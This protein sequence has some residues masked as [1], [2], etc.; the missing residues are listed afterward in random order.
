L[1]QKQLKSVRFTASSRNWSH[2]SITEILLATNFQIMPING[3]QHHRHRFRYYLLPN[4]FEKYLQDYFKHRQSTIVIIKYTNSFVYLPPI[5][6]PEYV[7][8]PGSLERLTIR[9]RY[10]AVIPHHLSNTTRNSGRS[11]VINVVVVQ[12]LEALKFKLRILFSLT[13]AAAFSVF[14]IILFNM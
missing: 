1:T 7:S 3:F 13:V 12:R 5:E 10:W 4:C 8:P 11:Q 9:E 14:K 6:R 2:G